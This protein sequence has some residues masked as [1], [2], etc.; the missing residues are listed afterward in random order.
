MQSEDG[1]EE[2][3]GEHD[4]GGRRTRSRTDEHEESGGDGRGV[5][6]RVP[7]VGADGR[8]VGW[9]VPGV[10]GRRTRSRT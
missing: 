8:G 7:G 3:G 1:H 9:R 6:G 2:S 10:G 4:V 5:G